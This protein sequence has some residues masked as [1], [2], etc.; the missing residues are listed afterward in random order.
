M[1]PTA[2]VC[3][4]AEGWCFLIVPSCKSPPSCTRLLSPPPPL[5][6]PLPPCPL[7]F[8]GNCLSVPASVMMVEQQDQNNATACTTFYNDL[9]PSESSHVLAVHMH[10][11]QTCLCCVSSFSKAFK[12]SHS[13]APGRFLLPLVSG[14]LCSLVC[15]AAPCNAQP[16]APPSPSP[17]SE[18]NTVYAPAP[19]PNNTPM[20]VAIVVSVCVCLA[21]ILGSI[22][23]LRYT[24]QG[25]RISKMFTKGLRREYTAHSRGS[26]AVEAQ[27]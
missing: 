10:A 9:Y 26:G 20:I 17:F 11:A 19:P 25:R 12:E 6:S 5:P 22:L 3:M 7:R 2:R 27:A 8:Y 18:N 14:P 15:L 4:P 21:V 16:P 24:R 13:S 1:L 23:F